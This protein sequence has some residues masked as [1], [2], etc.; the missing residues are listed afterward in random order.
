MS[1]ERRIEARDA[2]QDGMTAERGVITDPAEIAAELSRRLDPARRNPRVRDFG[3]QYLD[4]VPR[5]KT[6]DGLELSVQTGFSH[7]C[8]PRDGQGPWYSVELGFPSRRVEDFM[9]YIDGSEDSDPT[10]SVYGYVPI[11]VVA[12][13]L[14]QAGGLLPA[15][16]QQVRS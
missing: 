2:T 13:A 3:D 10:E 12:V 8:Q 7:Y 1:T 5:V 16:A 14:A 15:K 9:P 6:A 11:E 4:L